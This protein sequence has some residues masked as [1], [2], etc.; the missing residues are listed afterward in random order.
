MAFIGSFEGLGDGDLNR[1]VPSSIHPAFL[2]HV[3]PGT[4]HQGVAD[5]A[6]VIE[7]VDLAFGGT[8][9]P[10]EV[11]HPLNELGLNTTYIVERTEKGKRSE[12][13]EKKI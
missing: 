5:R 11:H 2:G 8:D 1:E 3:D 4:H 6:D 12:K 9:I 10:E 13:K 7:L